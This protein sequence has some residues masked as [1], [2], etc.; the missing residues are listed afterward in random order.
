V[1]VRLATAATKPSDSLK[2]KIG[3]SP[4]LRCAFVNNMPDGAFDATERQ[5]VGLL[6]DVSASEDIEVYRY[7]MSGVPRGEQTSAR[8]A[9]EYLPLT[10]IYL[11]PP[12]VLIV[13]GSNP[14]ETHIQDEL[15]WDDLVELL[16][17]ARSN[18]ASTLLS[19]LSAH[20]ALTVYDD[21][22]RVRLPAKCTGVFA[23]EV[24]DA[25]PLAEGLE[26]EILLPHSRWNSVP[27]EALELANYDIVIRS[28]T[29]GWS[30]A[31]RTEDGRQLVLVQGHPE[32]DPSSLL[33]EYRRDAGRYV[34]HERDDLPFLPYHCVAPNDWVSLEQMHRE[35]I[36][37][38][39]EPGLID[40]YPFD[41]VAARAPW[42]W[43]SMAQRFYANWLN[44][45]IEKKD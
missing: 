26:S 45:V 41:E 8:I 44:S 38:N 28:E 10:G 27:Q 9:E 24:E 40:T 30:V 12:D 3:P 25:H 29:T 4:R 18:V 17:W 23:Q 11:N 43:R 2:E 33:R 19:C 34:H 31:S 32:Y 14:L 39:R 7:T 21:L 20:A 35:I 22:T 13:T 16:T 1:T 37:G 15:Y 42:P 36:R 6:N 5:Y